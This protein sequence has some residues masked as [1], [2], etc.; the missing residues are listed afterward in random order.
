MLIPPPFERLSRWRLNMLQLSSRKAR[1]QGEAG[2]PAVDHLQPIKRA[3]GNISQVAVRLEVSGTPK[4]GGGGAAGRSQPVMVCRRDYALASGPSQ[5]LP[6]RPVSVE[7]MD[8]NLVVTL[9]RI[10]SPGLRSVTQAKLLL[11]FRSGS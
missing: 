5:D 9:R 2:S 11:A 6:L 3:S 7:R 1:G 10:F 8:M 4:K